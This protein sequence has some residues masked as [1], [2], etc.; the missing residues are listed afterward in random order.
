MLGTLLGA[1]LALSPGA[2]AAQEPMCRP[3]PERPRP[4]KVEIYQQIREAHG[5]RHDRA[6]VRR[7]MKRGV[8]TRDIERFPVT[9]RERRYVELRG[10][11]DLGRRAYRYLARRPAIDGGTSIEDAWPRDPYLLVRVTRDRAKHA[12]AIRRL[13]LQPRY[14][15]M[16]LVE[17]SER[18]LDRLRDRIDTRAAARDGIHVKI[19]SYDTDAAKVDLQ[20][21]TERADAA[22]Y[23]RERYGP[24]IR[25]RVIARTLTSPGCAGL[26]DATAGPGPNEV[27]I[28]WEGG[29]GATFDHA[30]VAEYDDRV[31][32]GV[33]AQLPNGF[34][35]ADLR[36]EQAVVTLS[37]PL[38]DRAVIDATTGRTPRAP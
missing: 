10:R 25:V 4:T 22:A 15:R 8:Y 38:G 30:Q 16:K 19:S 21:I 3:L 18:A 17:L 31:V 13:A 33:V 6:Y 26:W 29:G 28:G 2:Q 27:T 32:I 7:L 35:T 14:V 20:V 12:R 5:F 23:F 11:L 34:R 9:R 1:V 24:R 36:R 37:R